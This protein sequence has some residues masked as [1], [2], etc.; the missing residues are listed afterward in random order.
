MR[1]KARLKIGDT[2]QV[3]AGGNKKKRAN[4]GQ[5]GKILKFVGANKDRVIVSGVNLFSFNKKASTPGESSEQVKKEGSIHVSN[6]MYFSDELN[7]PVRLRAMF[8]KDGTKVRAYKD[9]D[10]LVQI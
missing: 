6:V 7:K 4:K 2:V 3:I 5:T 1:N 10:K 9:G 8:L